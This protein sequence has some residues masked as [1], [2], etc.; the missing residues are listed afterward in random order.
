M[1]SLLRTT[2]FRFKIAIGLCWF[3][4]AALP[5]ADA[6]ALQTVRI[7]GVALTYPDG[8]ADLA[9]RLAAKIPGML[10]FFAD[11]GLP[12]RTPLQV[13]ID[14]DRD[15]PRAEVHVIPHR[16]I[17]I[18][19]R[20]PGV[21]ED[22]CLEADP[23]AYFLFMGLCRHGIFQQVGGLPAALR[24]L[25]GQMM[26]PNALSP[27]WIHDGVG[28]Y[29]YRRY[30]PDAR[31]NPLDELIRK[32]VPPPDLAHLSNSGENWPGP[33]V[34]R[35]YGRS[36]IQWVVNRFGWSA[37]LSFFQFHGRGLL[38]V[39]VATKA[40]RAFGATWAALWQQYRGEWRQTGKASIVAAQKTIPLVGM[41][42]DGGS[43]WNAAGVTPGPQRFRLRGRYGHRTRED[44]LWLSE[45]DDDGRYTLMAYRGEGRFTGRRHTWDP[46]AGGVA[47]GR[48][49]RR[50]ILLLFDGEPA[51]GSDPR[52][53]PAPPGVSQLS[54]PVRS[55]QGR[56]AVAGNLSGNW[57]IWL[58]DTAWHRLT[59]DPAMDVDP[60]F[61][62]ERL[63]FASDREGRFRIYAVVADDAPQPVSRCATAALLP[64]GQRY[65]CLGEDGWGLLALPAP[66]APTAADPL[67]ASTKRT[68]A[69]AAEPPP[70]A[71]APNARK[72]TAFQ[73][74][75]PNYIRPDMF[76]RGSDLQLGLAT[77]G[78]DLSREV[79]VDA[80]F[81][82]SFD[83]DQFSWR[84]GGRGHGVGARL[85]RYPIEYDARFRPPVEEDRLE[86]QLSYEL[87]AEPTLIL[88]A[89]YR[90]VEPLFD[91]GET[92][93]HY[94]GGLRLEREWE[95]V[96]AWSD[97][98]VFEGGS[99][100]LF[101]G[102][103]VQVGRERVGVLQVMGGKT[104]G[105]GST[106]TTTYRVGGN[107]AE[108]FFTQRPSRLFPIRGFSQ[109]LL[110]ND[111]AAVSNL[112]IYWPLANLQKGYGTLPLFLHRLRLGTFVDVGTAS[113]S[114]A[115]DQL[116]VGAGL[117]LVTSMEIIW[118]F[119]SLF[120]L[121]VAWPLH[122]PDTLDEEGP[123]V[124]IQLGR[125][126]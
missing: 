15:R 103:R 21:F 82:Y 58:Y 89:N 41:S 47:V 26:S 28:Y 91:V 94:W 63:R 111:T 12:I 9:A 66:Q 35:I 118:G 1:P 123:V 126:L 107:V 43:Y 102:G 27:A 124:L 71:A 10:T 17:R 95:M 40:R 112:E 73:S 61:E 115:T 74:V 19:V 125:P 117:E 45:I 60:W 62:G 59:D 109:N 81:R 55:R 72:Y 93:D 8:E 57:E 67:V 31:P 54:G 88:S 87:W 101:G 38:P 39:E 84:F 78:E 48:E 32:V 98:E 70:P 29:L 99:Q 36:F 5:P 121:G 46:G 64:R 30:A 14:P 120:R 3:L 51:F 116:L 37:L 53:V 22:G 108:G 110:E 75:W 104:W 113:D 50:P 69:G 16:Q 122:Q 13:I 33:E 11:H 24:Y 56:V 97:L 100:S 44:R 23:W 4:I 90:H 18:P 86:G 25:F 42:R 34:Y 68:P 119:R 106:G 79:Q 52:M 49:G 96:T 114:L 77:R 76:Y 7:R 85:T 65:L 83:L 20:A 80:G 6:S 2:T 92:A 105:P